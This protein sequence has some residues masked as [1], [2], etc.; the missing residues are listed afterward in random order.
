MAMMDNGMS[1]VTCKKVEIL[2]ALRKNRDAHRD[3][4]LAA[5]NG[6]RKEVIAELE[7]S[8]KDA[9]EGRNVQTTIE[10]EAP[11][12]HTKDYDRIIRMLEMS[13]KDEIEVSELQFQQYVLD[14]WTWKFHFASNSARY[15]GRR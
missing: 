9:R 2:A 1:N 15:V 5:Q 13:V 12:D 3:I 4:F 14:D 6:Y 8:L 10:L 7:K 11:E